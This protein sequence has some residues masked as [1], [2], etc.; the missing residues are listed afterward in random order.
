MSGQA[1][2]FLGTVPVVSGL[3]WR[4]GQLSGQ[5]KLSS[6]LDRTTLETL[7]SMEGR[8]IVR[9]GILVER[10]MLGFSYASMEGRT[11]VRPG[12]GAAEAALVAVVGF[13]GGPDN[14][15]A[16]PDGK[17]K[18][19]DRRMRAS[20]EGRTIVRPGH[21]AEINRLCHSRASME[22]RTIVRPGIVVSDHCHIAGYASM[23]GRTIVRPGVL[24]PAEASVCRHA[25]MEGRTIVRP[26][27]SKMRPPT[28]W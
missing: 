1:S 18:R 5:A 7:A 17:R 2:P 27:P 23:E 24:D 22:G 20:M 26:G 14:C 25:S 4:A 10:D 15:P 12:Q 6:L 9:P 8:T 19:S 11:I 16:R 13:N 3:Q 28:V 21:C